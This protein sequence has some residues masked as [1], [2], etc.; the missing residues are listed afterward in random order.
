MKNEPIKLI[1]IKNAFEFC[2]LKNK[3]FTKIWIWICFYL[4]VLPIDKNFN[5]TNKATQH[6]NRKHIHKTR[7]EQ[8]KRKE[9]RRRKTL[10]Q[11]RIS[12]TLYKFEN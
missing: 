8:E 3:V 7:E 11:N 5:N 6:A 10:C 2:Y 4:F 9:K 1:E 12:S